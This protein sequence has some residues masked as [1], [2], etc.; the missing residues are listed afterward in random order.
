MS[1]DFIKKL[2]NKRTEKKVP[3]SQ[4]DLIEPWRG[5][6]LKARVLN[7]QFLGIFQTS[8]CDQSTETLID[9]KRATNDPGNGRMATDGGISTFHDLRCLRLAHGAA[10]M[11]LVCLVEKSIY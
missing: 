3:G 2:A 5:L 4:K 9:F 10:K 8:W 1:A 11:T 7:F 6:A